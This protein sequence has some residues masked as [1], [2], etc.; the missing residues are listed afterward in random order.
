[1]SSTTV[2]EE[3]PAVDLAG[4]LHNLRT[5]LN[6]IIGFSEMLVEIAE[7]E[8]HHDLIQGLDS[9]REAGTELADLFSDDQLFATETRAGSDYWPLTDAVR[10]AI[11]R[12]VGFVEVVLAEAPSPRLEGY[13]ADL[14]KIRTAARHFVELVQSSSLL[15]HLGTA[16][17]W[18]TASSVAP[19]LPGASDQTG[20]R[21]LVV[22]D[23]NLNRE[24]LCR[25][26]QREGYRPTGAASGPEALKLI[27]K[28]QFDAI[29][30]DILMPEMSGMEVLGELKED[31]LLRHLP[32]IMLSALTDVDRVA[33]C[34]ELG[35]DDYLSKPLTA[36]L[37][38]A[39][40][41]ASLEKQK[42][43][44]EI[45]RASKLQSV[46]AL[47]GGIAHDFNNMLTAV[48]GNLSLAL[49][50]PALPA[51][52]LP[53]LEEAIG[54]A[55]RA[56]EVTRH[57]LTFSEGGAPIKQTLR[58]RP[59][60]EETSTLVIAGSNVQCRFRLPD[61]LWDTEADPSQLKQVISSIVLNAVEAM[62]GGGS[63]CISA[64][65]L[66]QPPA[67]TPLPAGEYIAVTIKDE[68]TGIAPGDLQR[69]YD[70]F[71][72]TK[73]QSRGLGLAAAYSIIQR[74]G[75]HISIDS[76]PDQGTTA[77][78]YLRAS[79]PHV[80]AAAPASPVAPGE[81]VEPA[82]PAKQR[83]VLMMDDDAAIRMLAEVIFAQM[84]FDVETAPDGETALAA[85][86]AAAA[87]G[88]PFDLVI[89]DLT[90]PGGMG[91][92]EA[93]ALLRKKD[94]SVCTI[95]SSGYSNDPVMSQHLEHGFNAVLPKPYTVSDLTALLR[96]LQMA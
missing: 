3:L 37:L 69:I 28:E 27:R 86:A 23:E 29:L 47:A 51:E 5:P 20:S 58:V 31:P 52:L 50:H 48:L 14:L 91:G 56:Q 6:Q 89:M 75:G 96:T 68:G 80:E 39:R 49:Q 16:R 94:T 83:R 33:R 63:T 15:I 64:A 74:H 32:V 41:R 77:R 81:P 21:V 73:R 34:I 25:R 42:L 67:D 43:A 35:A 8:G 72:T 11:S 18:D 38:R 22:D 87:G 36:V 76:E 7:E 17:H 60:I 10:T 55:V 88:K 40:L 85:H 65:N 46:G 90:I 1:M 12:I 93:I 92:K 66:V 84:N 70:P 95:V 13:R 62:P 61:D 57:L 53:R 59:L 2:S 78:I 4:R 24:V 79:R 71:F 54:G 30:L 44:G 45:L 19:A 26:L 9:M 82:A